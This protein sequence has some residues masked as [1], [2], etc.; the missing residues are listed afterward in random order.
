LETLNQQEDALIRLRQESATKRA[1][2][3][4]AESAVGIFVG[5]LTL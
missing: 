4:A 5:Q 3:K 1:E 2:V